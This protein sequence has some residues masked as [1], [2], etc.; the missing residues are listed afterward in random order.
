D[1]EVLKDELETIYNSA[2]P[3]QVVAEIKHNP[4][5]RQSVAP[6]DYEESVMKNM[7]KDAALSDF[8]KVPSIARQVRV[9]RSNREG[10]RYG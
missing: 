2:N 6:S 1:W 9:A 3:A 5:G 10:A 8:Q 7:P 4:M